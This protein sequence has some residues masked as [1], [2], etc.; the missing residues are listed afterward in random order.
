MKSK[1]LFQL[2]DETV[3]A[4]ILTPGPSSP[5]RETIR[6]SIWYSGCHDG[7]PVSFTF[8]NVLV[9][10]NCHSDPKYIIREWRQARQEHLES[11]QNEANMPLELSNEEK[12]SFSKIISSVTGIPTEKVSLILSD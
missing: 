2:I 1:V 3:Q 4:T 5:L 7:T 6:E 8:R 11:I 9:T 12:N 10:V